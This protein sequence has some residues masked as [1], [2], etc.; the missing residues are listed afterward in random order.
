MMLQHA[1]LVSRSGLR[2]PG[3]A[4]NP[5]ASNACRDLLLA[6]SEQFP[7]SRFEADTTSP[8][9]VEKLGKCWGIVCGEERI[10][11]SDS[12]AKPESRTHGEREVSIE[13]VMRCQYYKIYGARL[14]FC[15]SAGPLYQLVA[16]LLLLP[17][18]NWGSRVALLWR[19]GCG[20]LRE[21]PAS[22]HSGRDEI[23]FLVVLVL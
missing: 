10:V 16:R 2:A 4:V 9:K 11:C 22:K 18:G 5:P 13:C 12:R 17:G 3:V 7:Q 14:I 23:C 8:I 15:L 21:D 6:P 20:G 19:S 1:T